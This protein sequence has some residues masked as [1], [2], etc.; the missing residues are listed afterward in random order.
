MNEN[1]LVFFG[2]DKKVREGFK[3]EGKMALR[4]ARFFQQCYGAANVIGVSVFFR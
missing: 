1:H 4:I 3:N 2:Y